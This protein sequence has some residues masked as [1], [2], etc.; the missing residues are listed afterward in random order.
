MIRRLEQSH[1]HVIGYSLSGEVTEDEYAQ[2]ASELR[3]DIARHGRIRLLFRLK[4]LSLSAFFT[5]LD[6]RFRFVDE[7]RDDIERIA[8][9]SDDTATGVLA[10]VAGGWSDIEIETFSHDDETTAWA[11]LE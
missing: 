1:D 2:A 5:A 4:D 10:K 3:D 6:E 11:W 9:V 7:H 8:V